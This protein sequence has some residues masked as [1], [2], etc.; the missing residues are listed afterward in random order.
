MNSEKNTNIYY[1]YLHCQRKWLSS[2]TVLQ[3][4]TP[5][6]FGVYNKNPTYF[7]NLRLFKTANL[8][9]L[10]DYKRKE[11]FKED[12]KPLMLY[13][14]YI[15]TIGSNVWGAAPGQK[16]LYTASFGW[17]YL[18]GRRFFSYSFNGVLKSEAEQFSQGICIHAKQIKTYI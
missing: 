5:K 13:V 12:G 16:C 8:L 15:Y 2:K 11:C 9:H 14:P 18:Q 17:G 3:H 7:T 6:L 4:F 1:L 10:A